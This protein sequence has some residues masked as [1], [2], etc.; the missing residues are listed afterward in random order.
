MA[1]NSC[2]TPN[3]NKAKRRRSSVA[4]TLRVVK[5]A[6]LGV[7][8]KH[9]PDGAVLE[10]DGLTLLPDGCI[11]HF[12]EPCAEKAGASTCRDAAM[13]AEMLTSRRACLIDCG[14]R[15]YF[16]RLPS[17]MASDYSVHD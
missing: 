7:A 13:P 14:S 12:D 17:R 8:A 5:K 4:H 10:A 16:T 15:S 6:G 9:T 1:D 2:D 11:A 3:T